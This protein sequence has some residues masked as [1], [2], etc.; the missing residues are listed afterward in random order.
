M[1]L[2]FFLNLRVDTR[3]DNYSDSA[4]RCNNILVNF[5]LQLKPNGY[6]KYIG[7]HFV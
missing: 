6:L 4:T 7:N 1:K 5:A 3:T 2:I